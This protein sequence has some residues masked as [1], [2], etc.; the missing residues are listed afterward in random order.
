MTMSSYDVVMASPRSVRFDD[1]VLERL[2]RLTHTA[3][4]GQ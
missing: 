4:T 1:D 3:C 2:G